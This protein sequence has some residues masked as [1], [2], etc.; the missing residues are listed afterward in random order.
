MRTINLPVSD[1][2][3][4]KSENNNKENKNRDDNKGG[5]RKRTRK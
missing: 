2:T 4:T 3:E 5:E 1:P